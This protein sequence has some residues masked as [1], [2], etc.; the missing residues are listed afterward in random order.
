MKPVKVSQAQPERTAVLSCRLWSSTL[1]LA[2]LAVAPLPSGRNSKPRRS[3]GE[4]FRCLIN[5]ANDRWGVRGPLTCSRNAMILIDV[6]PA[7]PQ[8]AG[9][10]CRHTRPNLG[11]KDGIFFSSNAAQLFI[12]RLD[13]RGSLGRRVYGIEIAKLASWH[14]C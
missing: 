11:M 14:L 5:Q 4:L 2:A 10:T 1:I 8:M 13:P 3:G 9:K 7:A 6:H 12:V